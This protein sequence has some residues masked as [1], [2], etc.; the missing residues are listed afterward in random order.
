MK[1]HSLLQEEF[2][3][4]GFY[5]LVEWNALGMSGQEL[6]T[7]LRDE[8][9]VYG[10]FQPVSSA[11]GLTIKVAY[12]EVALLYLHLL[13]SGRL[14][15]YCILADTGNLRETLIRMVLDQILEIA[16][17]GDFVGGPAAAKVIMGDS[18]STD[19]ILSDRLAQLSL[20]GII[21]AWMLP[22]TAVRSIAGR[23][24][25]LNTIPWDGYRRAAF[26]ATDRKSV[27]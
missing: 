9:E 24:Y 27:V 16:V 7:H 26:S 2:R 17:D 22:Q 19:T 1:Y 10:V 3:P 25:S 8:P 15:R 20:D 5:G 23:L 4:S 14:P 6:L 18:N 21:Y 11:A 12:R 13:H